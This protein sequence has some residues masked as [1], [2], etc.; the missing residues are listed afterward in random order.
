[1]AEQIFDH[2]A[3]LEPKIIVFA[4]A[5]LIVIRMG[6]FYVCEMALAVAAEIQDRG[7][8]PCIVVDDY[9]D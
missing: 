9:R 4:V 7:L 8:Y 1:M 3:A 5:D 6:I 2:S